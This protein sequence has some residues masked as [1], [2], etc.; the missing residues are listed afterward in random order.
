MNASLYKSNIIEH[1]K[2]PRNISKISEVTHTSSVKNTTCGDEIELS[3]NVSEGVVKE[4]QHVT[5]GC[6]ICLASMS[7]LSEKLIEKN[8]DELKE[9]DNSVVLDMLGM[10]ESSGRIKCAAL[11][12]EAVKL[13]ISEWTGELTA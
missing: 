7:M 4:L 13:I 5:R 11:G 8:V 6:A 9:L 3:L 12:V 1:Y 10:K 2:N